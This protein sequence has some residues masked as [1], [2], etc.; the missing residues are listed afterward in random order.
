ME[1]AV[2]AGGDVVGAQQRLLP[3]LQSIIT[4][5]QSTPDPQNPTAEVD[6]PR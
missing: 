2:L 3:L 4:D 1:A 6:S 5:K